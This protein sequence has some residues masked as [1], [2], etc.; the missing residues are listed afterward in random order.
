MFNVQAEQALKFCDYLIPIIKMVKMK[1]Y[2]LYIKSLLE[3]S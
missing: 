3:N 2:F 1:S